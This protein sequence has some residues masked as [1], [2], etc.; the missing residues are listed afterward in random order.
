MNDE[1]TV[2]R[3]ADITGISRQKVYRFMIKSGFNPVNDKG[4]THYYSV[5]DAEAV[6]KH[7]TEQPKGKKE[8]QVGTEVERLQKQVDEL[9]AQNERLTKLV[10]QGQ[11]LL[12]NEQ[13]KSK[14]L[15][16]ELDK[17]KPHKQWW[18]FWK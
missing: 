12:L 14:Q 17:N 4:K 15:Q 18:Q 6:I 9:N 3:I 16:L 1:W 11:Q 10:D 5:E 8:V 7:F 13:Q 2:T